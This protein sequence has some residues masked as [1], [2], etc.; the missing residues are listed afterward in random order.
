MSE[1]FGLAEHDPITEVR[2]DRTSEALAGRGAR[3]G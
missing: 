3:F 2:A 1:L